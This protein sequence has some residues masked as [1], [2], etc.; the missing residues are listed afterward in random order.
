MILKLM[1]FNNICMTRIRRSRWPLRWLQRKESRRRRRS[2]WRRSRSSA[3]WLPSITRTSSPCTTAWTAPHMYTSSWRLASLIY[4]LILWYIICNL[5]PSYVNANDAL[6]IVSLR[7]K[8]YWMY[9]VWYWW[10]LKQRLLVVW[11]RFLDCRVRE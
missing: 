11:I 1:F 10:W 2:S 3:S 4:F 9:F 7:P 8:N 5:F 6:M